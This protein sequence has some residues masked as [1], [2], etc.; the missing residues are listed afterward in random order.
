MVNSLGFEAHMYIDT[1]RFYNFRCS[2]DTEP[3]F[4]FADERKQV[5]RKEQRAI[6][7]QFYVTVFGM[8]TTKETGGIPQL[9]GLKIAKGKD[10]DTLFDILAKAIGLEKKILRKQV[11]TYIKGHPQEII[12]VVKEI[13]AVIS[14]KSSRNYEMDRKMT[15][16]LFLK[17][18]G[19]K[20][21]Y[22][23]LKN[24]YPKSKHIGFG[25]TLR[26]INYVR[27]QLAARMFHLDIELNDFFMTTGDMWSGG[28][29]IQHRIHAFDPSVSN[30]RKIVIAQGVRM[31]LAILTGKKPGDVYLTF[32]QPVLLEK[33]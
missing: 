13:A 33:A 24:K 3:T 20:N 28:A 10:E 32:F 31:H 11:K 4:T 23:L 29:H 30:S 6:D 2:T 7:T 1:N 16:D 14:K 26:F 18:I 27:C 19:S 15:R 25:D 22:K 5:S 12:S 8:V 17:L 21:S 9:G